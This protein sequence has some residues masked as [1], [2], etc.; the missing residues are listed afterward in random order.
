MGEWQPMA[1]APKDG[2]KFLVPYPLWDKGNNTETPTECEVMIIKW[3]GRCWDTGF[4]CLHETPMYWQPLPP[5][6]PLEP[7]R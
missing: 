5:A 1:T 7:H 6:P 3:N 2:S 4:W